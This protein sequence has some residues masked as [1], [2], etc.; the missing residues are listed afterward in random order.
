MF[1]SHNK[2]LL[3]DQINCFVIMLVYICSLQ[4]SKWSVC[5]ASIF[6]VST[7]TYQTFFVVSE[8]HYIIKCTSNIL[9]LQ[10]HLYILGSWLL[11]QTSEICACIFLFL[12]ITYQINILIM[13]YSRMLTFDQSNCFV[14]YACI[15]LFSTVIQ[16]LNHCDC[17][18]SMSPKISV[19]SHTY[20]V[21]K[22]W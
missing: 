12:I 3:N 22:C 14:R 15:F 19:L 9:L 2:L 10:F 8:L 4:W 13:G 18:F 1:L 21:R 7:T 16:T 6:L 20:T 5:F 11:S 17:T